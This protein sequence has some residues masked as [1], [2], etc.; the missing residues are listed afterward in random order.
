MTHTRLV[1][2][3]FDALYRERW[4]E[5]VAQARSILRGHSDPADVAATAFTRL[6]AEIS[7]GRADNLHARLV[8]LTKTEAETARQRSRR[9]LEY[10]GYPVER[11]LV[12]EEGE[13][14]F[15][16]L[17]REKGT[18]AAEIAERMTVR[19]PTPEDVRFQT[20]LDEAVRSLTPK[21]RDAFILTEL[22]GLS[23]VEAADALGVTKQAV[24]KR[25]TRARESIATQLSEGGIT[26]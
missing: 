26:T 3:Q 5:I 16:V 24:S 4:D 7:D 1:R 22:R 8:E 21:Q 10:L 13:P 14:M 9:E 6:W 19:Q 12:A 20:G 2:G 11:T 18:H 23:T 25:A 17:V 15:T